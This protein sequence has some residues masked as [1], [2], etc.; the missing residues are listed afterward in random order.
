MF[1]FV[2]GGVPS[3]QQNIARECLSCPSSVLH[4]NSDAQ[5]H[6]VQCSNSSPTQ[7]LQR[8]NSSPSRNL[9]NSNSS[10]SGNQ[11]DNNFSLHNQRNLQNKNSSSFHR[12]ENDDSCLTRGLQRGSVCR[13]SVQQRSSS[14]AKRISVRYVS[15]KKCF[16]IIACYAD[17]MFLDNLSL[18]LPFNA[19]YSLFDKTV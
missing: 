16:F 5:S 17:Y 3:S 12:Q 8:A 4:H 6:T 2:L 18:V 7:S 1:E 10:S 11:N 13:G 9:Q 14:P 15:D 19:L